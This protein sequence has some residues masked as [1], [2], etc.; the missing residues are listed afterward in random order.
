MQ[1]LSITK[2]RFSIYLPGVEIPEWFTYKNSG[3][4]SISVPLPKDCQTPTFMGIAICAVFDIITPSIFNNITIMKTFQE[5][6]M[7]CRLT[8]HDGSCSR[9]RSC[10]GWIGSEKPQD[11]GNIFLGYVSIDC[12]LLKVLK[13]LLLNPKN[14]SQF[15]FGVY[16][17]NKI[18]V[19]KGLGL[20]FVYQNDI[21]DPK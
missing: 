7:Q 16:D 13:D 6:A 3:T 10:F 8:S 18:M 15:E 1:G 12:D 14:W 2:C 19:I 5:L 21:N 11:L 17:I 9:F 20:R 4:D